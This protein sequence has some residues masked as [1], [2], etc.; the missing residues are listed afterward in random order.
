MRP[1]RFLLTLIAMALVAGGGF[2]A[3]V[4]SSQRGAPDVP[5]APETVEEAAEPRRASV[6]ADLDAEEKETIALFETASPSVVFITTV[7]VQQDLFSMNVMEVPQGSGSGFIWDRAGHIVTNFHVIAGADAAQVTLSD[8]SAWPAR[9]IGGAPEKDLAVL[10][11]EAPPNLLRPIAIGTSD[12]LRVGQKVLAIGNPFGFDQSLTTGVISALGREIDSVANI[13]IRD[14]I[15]TDA[16]INPGNSGGPL[17]DS[18][19]RVIGVNTAIYT[20]S[21]G[22]AGIGFAIPVHAVQAAVPD[23]IA[24][25]RVQRATL[26]VE[27]APDTV[28]RQAGIEGALVFRVV[29]GSGA[30]QAEL[31][32]TRRLQRGRWQLGDVIVGIGGTPVR[33]SADLLLALEERRGGETVEIELVRDGRRATARVVLGDGGQVRGAERGQV[34]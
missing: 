6:R 2:L 4:A 13:P 28:L 32:G 22:S 3:G 33:S 26:G 12:D 31:R 29:P 30:D 7:A 14:V 18:A 5:P 17:L 15:Q 21:G 9:L 8:H 34:Q 1:G 11:I 27:L 10:R 24:H 23:L 25:G 19:G 16:A 20:P